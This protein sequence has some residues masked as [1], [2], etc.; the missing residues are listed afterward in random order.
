[1]NRKSYHSVVMQAVVDSRYMFR[2]IVVGW[3]GS[4]H[5]A[6]VLSNSKLYDLGIK[7]EL[8]DSNIKQTILGCHI[9]PLILGDP[10]YP[11]LNWLMKGYP[12]NPNTPYWQRHFNYRLSRARM[13]V[14]NTFGRWK[15]CFR[16][17]L[18]RV[19]TDVDVLRYVVLASCIIHNICELRKDDFLEEW[20][21][22]I[23]GADE[24]P[25]NIPRYQTVNQTETDAAEIREIIAVYF[26]TREG[27]NRGTG[28]E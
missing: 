10:V 5:D 15:G 26:T 25:D 14:E 27:S 16:R 23:A 9:R 8:F 2:D 22:A 18:K 13:T 19:G 21:E 28:G 7:E 1:M 12:E 17:F 11:F 24:Q 3:P 6:R 4:V 20:L